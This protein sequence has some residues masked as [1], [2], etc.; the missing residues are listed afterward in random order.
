MLTDSGSQAVCPAP[1]LSQIIQ[2]TGYNIIVTCCCKQLTVIKQLNN[3]FL[4]AY[5]KLDVLQSLMLHNILVKKK[6][7]LDQFRKGLSI[8]GLLDEIQRKPEMFE[9]CFVYQGIVSNDSVASSLHFPAS[10][11]KNA[12]SVFQLL[13]TFIK[14]CDADG[15]DD[16]LRFVTGTRCSAKSILARRITVSCESTNSIF[17]STCLLELKLPNHF[18]NYAEFEAAM[19]SVIGGNTFTTG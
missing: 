3:V 8:L 17:A 1:C 12:Q 2:A 7:I 6:A 14:N 5:N 16:F 4:Q 19:H 15:L 10:E 9:E 11:D 18:R 13:Q